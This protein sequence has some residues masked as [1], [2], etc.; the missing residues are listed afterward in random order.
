MT[1][2]VRSSVRPVFDLPSDEGRELL[3]ARY[4]VRLHVATTSAISWPTSLQ[5]IFV[6]LLI[7]ALSPHNY[8]GITKTEPTARSTRMSV[9]TSRHNRIYEHDR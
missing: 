3:S 8:C 9:T 5:P 4:V 2:L 1:E 7:T 6:V